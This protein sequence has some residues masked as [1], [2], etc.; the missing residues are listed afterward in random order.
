MA[1][2]QINE[3]EWD[4]SKSLPQKI[5]GFSLDDRQVE[6]GARTQFFCYE[7]KVKRLKFCAMYDKN[8]KEYNVRR[9]VGLIEFCD[10]DFCAEDLPRFERFLSER[11]EETL[12]QMSFFDEATVD[13]IVKNKG[14]IE[15][16]RE[17]ELPKR[18]KAFSL[19][20][21]PDQPLKVINGS[22][23][24][25]DYSDFVTESNLVI[26]YNMFRDDFFAEIRVNRL[27]E[28]TTLFDAGTT[29]DLNGILQLHLEEV[30]TYMTEKISKNNA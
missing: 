27:P 26:Y 4:Y 6:I 12:T 1:D 3:Q 25:L 13:S 30:L 24:V 23:I 9:T 16:G 29:K 14:I 20:I 10:V 8:T 5:K 28:M 17:L 21:S 15:W 19:F 18:F 2:K 22:Y 11:M 7:D